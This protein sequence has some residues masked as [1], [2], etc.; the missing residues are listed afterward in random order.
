MQTCADR[1]QNA[2]RN[3]R[4]L[5]RAIEVLCTVLAAVLFSCSN[6][7]KKFKFHLLNET[8]M[9]TPRGSKAVSNLLYWGMGQRGL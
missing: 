6:V 4:K 7:K 8:I 5:L 9:D 2:A 3:L 1:S